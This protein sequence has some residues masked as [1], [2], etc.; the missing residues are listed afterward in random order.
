MFSS[1]RHLH[2]PHNTPCLHRKVLQSIVF[3]VSW[4]DLS[5]P[6]RP[7]CLTGR[8]GERNRKRA[9][10]DGKG[11]KRREA[12]AF[13]LFSSSPMGFLFFRYCNFYWDAQR[14]PLLRREWDNCNTQGKLKTNVMQTVWGASKL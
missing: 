13:S 14:K 12:P 11:Q 8:L 2:I 7:L 5:S 6:Q 4:D 1:I 3:D 10:H 9:G